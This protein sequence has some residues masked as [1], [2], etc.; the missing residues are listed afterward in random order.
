MSEKLLK[1]LKKRILDNK[2]I[3]IILLIG[4]TGIALLSLSEINKPEKDNTEELTNTTF[5]QSEEYVMSLENRLTDMISSIENAGQVK[6]MVTLKSSD[7]IKYAVNE[8]IKND[9]KSNN[10]SNNYVIIENKGSKE[11][12]KTKIIEPEIRGVAVVCSGGDDP[13]VVSSITSAVTTVL[14]I[15]AN[16]VSVS[17]MK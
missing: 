17:K 13:L 5:T 11:G 2:K 9:D 15:G 4:F 7:E 6:V 10:Y 12:I 3:F 16:K 8:N 1:E 14:G